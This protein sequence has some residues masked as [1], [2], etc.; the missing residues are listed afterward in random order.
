[1]NSTEWE[2][3]LYLHEFDE[4]WMRYASGRDS[5]MNYIGYYSPEF[6]FSKMLYPLRYYSPEFTFSKML[7]PLGPKNS[8]AE[9]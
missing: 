3:T 9:M 5:N 1:M 8:C 4:F 7:Y 6:T 2:I